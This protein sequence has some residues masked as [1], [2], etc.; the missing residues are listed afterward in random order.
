VKKP[1]PKR[2]QD[3]RPRS[4]IAVRDAV[5]RHR[6]AL[7]TRQTHDHRDRLDQRV[8]HVRGP[9]REGDSVEEIGRSSSS[10]GIGVVAQL[11]PEA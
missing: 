8:L 11:G 5:K 7:L 4:V 2:P 1:S 6:N 10:D 3:S 9:V